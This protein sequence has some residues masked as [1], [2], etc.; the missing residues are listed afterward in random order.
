MARGGGR[1]LNP[2]NK[3]SV[4]GLGLTPAIAFSATVAFFVDGELTL[5][6]IWC[7]IT[8]SDR[9]VLL[10]AASS[11]DGKAARAGRLFK[12]QD[13]TIARFFKERPRTL[14]SESTPAAWGTNLAHPHRLK[15]APALKF[16]QGKPLL[17]PGSLGSRLRSFLSLRSFIDEDAAKRFYAN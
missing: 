3:K 14:S 10:F 2:P 17:N 1:I 12:G 6:V 5:R 8:A 13:E 4:S 16:L 15:L 9:I 11:H 7:Q